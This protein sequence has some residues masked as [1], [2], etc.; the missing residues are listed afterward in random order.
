MVPRPSCLLKASPS[1][2]RAV[3]NGAPERQLRISST[4]QKLG[5]GVLKGSV[6]CQLSV[7]GCEC[8]W[9]QNRVRGKAGSGKGSENV[10]FFPDFGE[11]SLASRAL[12]FS[13]LRQ[14]LLS[15]PGLRFFR[16]SFPTHNDQTLIFPLWGLYV[17]YSSH[18]FPSNSAAGVWGKGQPHVTI[19][20]LS[21]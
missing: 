12:G 18:V 2:F 10:H 20:L 8:I 14:V 3:T 7:L 4:R 9:S 17:G 6:Q 21:F 1:L 19:F 5:G 15:P 16:K 13:S 11:R